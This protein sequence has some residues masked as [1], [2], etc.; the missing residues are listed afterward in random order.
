MKIAVLARDEMKK[1]LQAKLTGGE[2]E[3]Y[4]DRNSKRFLWCR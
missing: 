3:A 1:E 4:L 2:V